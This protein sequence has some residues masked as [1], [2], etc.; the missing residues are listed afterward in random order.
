MLNLKEYFQDFQ[1]FIIKEI[2][3]VFLKLGLSSF[4]GPIA[5]LGYFQKEFVEDRKWLDSSSYSDLVALCQF[6]PGPSSSQVGMAIGLMRAGVGGSFAAWLGF[7]LPS[8][9]TL[10]VAGL[11]IAHFDL[12]IKEGLLHGLKL[13][14]AAVI[15]QAIWNMAQSHC[16]EIK[17]ILISL[18]SAITIVL[19]PTSLNQL[20]VIVISAILGILVLEVQVTNKELHIPI[21]ISKRTGISIL[22]VF[23]SLLFILP[24]G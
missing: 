7:T 12:Y 15:A 18:M 8:A 4:G 21:S 16:R 9:I 6:L 11:G 20:A 22:S 24:V 3:F 10:V 13:V 1:G 19:V 23:V 5:H 2:F 17:R 14:A